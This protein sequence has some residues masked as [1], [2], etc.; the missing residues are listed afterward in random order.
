[1]AEG[2]LARLLQGLHEGRDLTDPE[3][4]AF[5]DLG[6]S[7]ASVVREGWPAV[8]VGTRAAMLERAL[9]LADVNVEL[10]FRAL[11]R[12]ALDDA[13][14]EVRERAI[15]LLWESDDRD[16]GQKLATLVSNDPGPGVRAAAAAGL[17]PFVDAY[18]VERLPNDAGEAILA[19]LCK[20]L[21]DEDIDVR[22]KAIESIGAFG[23]PW[24]G[25]RILEAFESDDQRLRVAAIRAMGNSGLDRW[26]EYLE[27]EFSS[28]DEEMRFEAVV[29]AGNLGSPLLVEPLGE[30]LDD[31]DPELVL[32]VVEA[33]GEIGGDD[34]IELLQEFAP[35]APE[36]FEEAIENALTAATH[37]GMFRRFG[38]LG[39]FIS[40]VSEESEE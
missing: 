39:S 23:E 16:V 35:H 2:T 3:Y 31:E 40:D 34:A 7:D 32:A 18:V 37:E 15:A 10:D 5:S 1:M 14:P 24:V 13:D 20:A 28:G 11:G 9:E 21:D 8:P 26:E 4:G 30:L 22:T 6:R 38:D 25:E 17:K 19:A 12:L 33:I 27:S 36:G 29:A